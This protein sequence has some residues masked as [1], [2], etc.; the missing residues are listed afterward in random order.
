MLQKLY[1][2]CTFPTMLPTQT[3]RRFGFICTPMSYVSKHVRK[4]WCPLSVATSL[5]ATDWLS[6][7]IGL[8]I[9]QNKK[10]WRIREV[11][12]HT[13]SLTC[14]QHIMYQR[15]F[16]DFICFCKGRFVDPCW[17]VEER[18]LSQQ[19]EPI[20]L[21]CHFLSYTPTKETITGKALIKYQQVE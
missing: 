18:N 5:H 15:G 12:L 2:Y 17:P 7:E 4:Q 8:R 11:S 3:Q 16:A 6:G 21:H 9:S 1:N 14:N 20:M 19:S 10:H 13:V